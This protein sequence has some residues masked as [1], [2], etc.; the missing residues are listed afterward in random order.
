[1]SDKHISLWQ[2]VKLIEDGN[3]WEAQKYT[4]NE[5]LCRSLSE[6]RTDMCAYQALTFSFVFQITYHDLLEEYV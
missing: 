6:K 2:C 1:M 5:D 3:V 4:I